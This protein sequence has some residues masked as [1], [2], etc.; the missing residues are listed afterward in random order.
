MFA[1]FGNIIL[2]VTPLTGPKALN[3]TF[4]NSYARHDVIRGKPVL[5]LIGEELDTR[6]IS[7]FFDE[8]FCDPAAQWATLWAAYKIK[9]AMPLVTGVSFDG[10]HFV[11]ETLERDVLKTTRSGWRVVR[12]EATMSLVEAPIPNLLTAALSTA[13]SQAA[14]LGS[15]TTKPDAQR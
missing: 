10:R 14:G 15:S 1:F 2:G 9:A 8:T 11:I 12:L 13:A 3:E 4:G 5:Q 6:E 7:F